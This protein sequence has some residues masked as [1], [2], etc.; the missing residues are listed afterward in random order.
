[1][2]N[3][4]VKAKVVRWGNEPCLIVSFKLSE[5][6]MVWQMDLAKLTDYSLRL[7]EKEGEWDLGYMT[8][9]GAFTLIAHFENRDASE[10][11]YKAVEKA[12]LSGSS[13]SAGTQRSGW[14]RTLLMLVG[15]VFLVLFGLN[16]MAG[17]LT[18]P[19]EI[20]GADK[21]AAVAPAQRG[22]TRTE[23]QLLI[24]EEQ[25]FENGVPANADDV[26]RSVE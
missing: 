14:L 12:L 8:P 13:E 16:F 2:F 5:P 21:T 4:S 7:V 24:R 22:E 1:M 25:K 19:Q 6:P 11:A 20:G 23:P 15:L 9:N 26:L 18:G 3:S 17:G 10:K